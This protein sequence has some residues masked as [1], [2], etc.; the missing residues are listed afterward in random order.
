MTRVLGLTAILLAAAA[1]L[2]QA[3]GYP[4]KPVTIVVP[5]SPGGPPDT[6]SRVCLRSRCERRSASRWWSRTRPAR[7]APRAFRGSSRAAPDG[8][9]LSV[10]HFNSHVISSITYNAYDPLNDLEPVAAL[11]TAPMVFVA[12]QGLLARTFPGHARAGGMAEGQSGQGD[13]RLGRCRRACAT[14]GARTFTRPTGVSFQF[15]P[16]RGAVLVVQ[17]M[18]AGHIDLGC[19]EGSNVLPHLRGDKIRAHAVLSDKRWAAAPDVPTIGETGVP[20][21]QMPFWHGMWAPKGTP[22]DVIARL[23]VPRL[24]ARWPIRR[25]A[26]GS[27]TLGRSCCLRI[28]GRR[29][30]WRRITR[31]K[32]KN[33]RRSSRRRESRLS[34]NKQ[35]RQERIDHGQTCCNCARARS[36]VLLRPAQ[37]QTVSVEADHHH[38]AVRGRR[39]E[40]R[41]GP[42]ARRAH[43]RDLEPDRRRRERHR[44][45]R[46]HR[47]HARDARS[48]ADGYTISFGHLGTHVVNGAIYSLPFDL[49]NDLEPVAMLGANPMLVVSKNALPAKDAA[50]ADR[51]GE[52][53]PGQGDVRHRGRR[54]RRA[55]QRRL[56]PEPDRHQGELR[57]LSRHRSG[58]AGS[59]RG[60]DRHH[61]RPGVE[62]AAAGQ[63][64]DDPRLCGDRHEA[65]SVGVEHPDR[66][67]SRAAGLPRVAVVRAV[68][69]EGHAE[70]RHRQA[71]RGGA[72]GVR[73]SGG[74][75]AL[76]RAGPGISGRRRSR[77]RRRCAR[78]RRPRSRNGG[79]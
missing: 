49:V 2:A 69:A 9:T 78:I 32:S 23:N 43:A 10:G 76:R 72:C 66:G 35:R 45:G 12:R 39:A 17:D 11:V 55:F 5:T 6:L 4:T 33:G 68:G 36:R 31:R 34:D 1:S 75:E 42:H 51:L 77:R 21:L 65:H 25:C 7:A 40:R 74:A 71:Q 58:I 67:G 46:H 59:G 47:R 16:Y 37:A 48:P 57:A 63:C 50:G 30:D 44:R 70:G 26:R 20:G 19:M 64:G 3:E 24:K 18:L 41:A 8:Y 28:C 14:S 13:V 54:L 53:E 15:I 29:R 61:R 56:F 52:G 22:P 79:R 27:P 62:L 60:P 73:R 38:R